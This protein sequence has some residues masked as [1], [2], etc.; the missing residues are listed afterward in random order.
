MSRIG[1]DVGGTNTDAI[2]IDGDK[3]LAAVKSPTTADVSDGVRRALADLMAQA[4]SLQTLPRIDAVMIGTTHF[5]NAVIE[6][7]A[8]DKVA[9]LRIGLPANA[10]LPPFIGWP[11][12][13]AEAMGGSVH[14]VRGGHDYDGRSLVPLDRAAVRAEAR[15]MAEAGLT[16]IAITS[17]FS[18]LTDECEREAA[19]IV[20]E[21]VSGA[22]ITLSHEIGRIGL[23]ERENAALLNAGLQSLAR[24][25]T[26]AFTAAIADSG[27]DAPLFLTQN[28]GTIVQGSVAESHPVYCFASGPTNSMRGAAFLSGIADALVVDVGGTTSDVGCLKA[29]FPRQANAAVEIGGVRTLFRMPDLLSIGLGGGTEISP[30]GQRIG[31]ASVGFRLPEKAL[32]FGGKTLTASDVAVAAGRLDLGDR[33]KVARLPVALVA[34]GLARMEHMIADAVDRMRTDATPLP[35]LAVG[36][37]SFLVPDQMP[38]ISQVVR[39]PHYAVANAVGAAIA[40]VSGEVDRI[41]TGLTREEALGRAQA[42]ATRRA[43]AAGAEQGSLQTLEMEDLPIAYLPGNAR[44]VRVRVIADIAMADVRAE[45]PS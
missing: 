9:A 14:M 25:T 23:L 1:I 31:P 3:V 2:L 42:E 37:G 24:R 10:G 16:A 22:R 36:G 6:R 15:R 33:G 17:V 44:R 19:Q 28:D 43:I 32:V 21:E 34:Q 29:G 26:A 39:V 30:D 5:T 41:F 38:G 40:Q 12:D 13:L 45:A 4:A 27:L 7:R 8:L 11:A 20:S 18:P 35:L